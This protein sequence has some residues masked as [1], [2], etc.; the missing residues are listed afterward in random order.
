MTRTLTL[1]APWTFVT[2]AGTPLVYNDV[3]LSKPLPSLQH[4]NACL[5]VLT[6]FPAGDAEWMEPKCQF[7]CEFFSHSTI[8]LVTVPMQKES[9][10]IALEILNA[11][12]N[13]C[14]KRSAAPFVAG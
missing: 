11:C 14:I 3:R 4:L 13:D 10:Y 6:V 2:I 7:W 8:R 1:R 9:F 12:L 5:I